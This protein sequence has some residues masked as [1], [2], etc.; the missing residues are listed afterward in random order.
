MLVNLFPKRVWPGSPGDSELEALNVLDLSG[1]VS[2]IH[3]VGRR[4]AFVHVPAL[5]PDASRAS[6]R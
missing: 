5:M 6:P 1:A 4:T 2:C 3:S